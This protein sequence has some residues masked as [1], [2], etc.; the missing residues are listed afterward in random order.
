M[1]ITGYAWSP[2]RNFESYRRIVV[3]LDKYD[4]ELKLKQNDSSFIT[5]EIPP[6]SYSIKDFSE[7][8]YTIGYHDVTLQIEIDDISIQ[9]KLALNRFGGFLEP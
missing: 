9:A 6:V 8:I 1:L 5:H 4:I 7:T 3:G 2:F